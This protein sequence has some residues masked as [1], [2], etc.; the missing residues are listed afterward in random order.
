MNQNWVVHIQIVGQNY[1]NISPYYSIIF[2]WIKWGKFCY[3]G[4]ILFPSLLY[5]DGVVLKIPLNIFVNF[6][7]SAVNLN[8]SNNF[9]EILLINL[10][11]KNDNFV[12]FVHD[13]I[14]MKTVQLWSSIAQSW[15]TPGQ[16]LHG[17]ITVSRCKTTISSR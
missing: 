6:K 15:P 9:C 16:P 1:K 10:Q 3:F 5:Q 12:F 4:I 17:I 2:C 8:Q 14:R 13:V 7:Q 11:T